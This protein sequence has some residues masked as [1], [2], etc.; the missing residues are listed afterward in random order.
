MLLS[1]CFR[2]P[3]SDLKEKKESGEQDGQG[4]FRRKEVKKDTSYFT[5]N[6]QIIQEKYPKKR[7]TKKRSQETT[8]RSNPILQSVKTRG[9]I[10]YMDKNSVDLISAQNFGTIS[11]IPV[12][13]SSS[14][15]IRAMPAK[16]SPGTRRV[17][18]FLGSL[19]KRIF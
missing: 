8:K 9:S 16:Y 15:H 2:D 17:S 3:Q 11:R 10:S 7:R 6:Q 5:N 1:C 18:T 13:T 4:R 14:Q 19:I 12:R